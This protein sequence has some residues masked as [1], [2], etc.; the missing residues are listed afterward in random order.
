MAS[1][2]I[3]L[4]GS[5]PMSFDVVAHPVV[6][7]SA[8]TA[9]VCPECLSPLVL[10]QPDE[11]QPDKLLGTCFVCF[12]WFLLIEIEDTCSRTLLVELPCA[13]RIRSMVELSESQV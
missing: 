5:I 11:D 3:R 4:A 6:L 13:D 7:V 2:Q 9:L 10:H 8:S 1:I 12:R